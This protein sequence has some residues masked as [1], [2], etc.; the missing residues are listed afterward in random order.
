MHYLIDL[1]KSLAIKDVITS[2]FLEFVPNSLGAINLANVFAC[3]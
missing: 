2:L 3:S 1:I